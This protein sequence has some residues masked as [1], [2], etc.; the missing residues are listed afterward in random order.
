MV[1]VDS[2]KLKHEDHGILQIVFSFHST[3]WALKHGRG[4]DEAR[5]A[6]VQEAR[7]A[8]LILVLTSDVMKKSGKQGGVLCFPQNSYN[9]WACS[10]K[11]E[12]A[13]R[14]RITLTC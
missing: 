14:A 6:Q 13:S 10:I 12:V 7:H 11:C 9:G 3:G 5:N 4:A 1:T 2:K 8:S